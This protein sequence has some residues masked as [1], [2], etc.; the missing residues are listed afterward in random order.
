MINHL[1]V[2][3]NKKAINKVNMNNDIDIEFEDL[4]QLLGIVIDS[5]FSFETHI[6]KLCEKVSW[7]LGALAT[8]IIKTFIISQL[9]SVV[10]IS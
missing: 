10:D 3:T 7:I 6:N 5:K 4:K 2:S 9:S 1:R 8:L